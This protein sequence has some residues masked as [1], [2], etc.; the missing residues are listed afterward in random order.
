VSIALSVLLHGALLAALV[1]GWLMF[2]Q[3]PRP[4]PTLAIEATVVE[5]RAVKGAG[6]EDLEKAPGISRTTARQLY[7]YF[8]PR[9]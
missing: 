2:R 5:A 7:D 8:H 6:L 9:G 3:P 4:A 1:Y